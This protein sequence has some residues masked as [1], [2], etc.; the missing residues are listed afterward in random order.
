MADQTG[1][2]GNAKKIRFAPQG[3]IYVA[4]ASS[5]TELPRDCEPIGVTDV[6]RALGYVDEGG[7]TITPSIETDPVNVWQSAVPVNA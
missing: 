3:E 6:F 4:E 1:N 5:V 7:V 2:S